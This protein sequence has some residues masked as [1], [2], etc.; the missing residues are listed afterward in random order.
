MD[1][2]LKELC[3]KCEADSNLETCLGKYTKPRLKQIL[4]IY[5]AKMPSAAKKQE[6]AEKAEESI[7]ENVISY[8][9]EEG[10]DRADM[11]MEMQALI[12]DGKTLTAYDDFAS[13]KEFFD[14]GLIYLRADGE[15]AEVVV[16]VN[17]KAIMEHVDEKPQQFDEQSYG[18]EA[19]PA[20]E[21]SQD[22]S[23]QDKEVIK[24]AAALANM[25]GVYP[26][27]QVKETWD[28][29]HQRAISPNDVR[30]ALL[31]AG[32]ADGF[33]INDSSYIISTMLPTLEDYF[34][35]LN[36]VRRSDTYYYPSEEVIEEFADGPVYKVA[37]E[38]YILRSYLTRKLGGDEEKAESVISE[39]YVVCARD[40]DDAKVIA[41]IN[42]KGVE[43]DD[44]ED[45]RRFMY[46][47]TC[48]GY[49][50]R[51]WQCKG[52]KPSE[53]RVEKLEYRNFHRPELGEPKKIKLTGRNDECP[54]GSGKKYK[55]CCMKYAE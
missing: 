13:I 11:K 32:D 39:L 26:A 33:Y 1:Q 40:D 42:S 8:F 24:Y 15:N 55:K 54:C 25:Y 4:D 51:I 12:R 45:R 30:S 10:S 3:I 20:K 17:V 9:N 34:A 7:K 38:Y 50:L 47:Y 46:L 44:D 52:Y 37:P 49:E 36:N 14:R 48:W 19:R 43:F 31:K 5:G 18:A 41:F 23:E 22:R 2:Q 27:N 35:A 6:M 28:F 16:P 53:L 21:G 29:N